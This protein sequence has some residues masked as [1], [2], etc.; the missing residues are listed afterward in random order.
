MKT[1]STSFWL[2]LLLAVCGINVLA[3]PV[4]KPDTNEPSIEYEVSEGKITFFLNHLNAGE[5]ESVD[6]DGKPI[7]LWYSDAVTTDVLANGLTFR[8]N[9]TGTITGA[10]IINVELADGRKLSRTIFGGPIA[11]LDWLNA[12]SCTTAPAIYNAKK[13]DST[14]SDVGTPPYPCCDNNGDGKATGLKDGNCTWLAW[15]RAKKTKG[16]TVPSNWGNASNWCANAAKTT[17]W[18]VSSTPAKDTIACS[19]SIGHV[20]WVTS[21]SSDKKTITIQEQN[22]RVPPSCVSSGGTRSKTYNASSFQYISKSDGTKP[23]SATASPSSG[24][25]TSS[26][27]N[28]TVSSSGA[29]TIY[30]TMVNTYDGSTPS[31]PPAPSPSS[32]NGS[33]AGASAVFQLYASAGQNKKTKLRFVGCNSAGC[34]TAS[35]SYSYQINLQSPSS[36]PDLIVTAVW[37]KEGSTIKKGSVVHPYCTVKNIGT[38]ASGAFRI[39]YYINADQYR[40]DDGVDPLCAGCSATEYVS[41]NNIK[42]GD[43]GNRT[44]RCCA[45]YKGEV[46]ESNESNNCSTISFVVR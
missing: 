46:S 11:S 38:A 21:V 39:A 43:A 33:L 7:D 13:C 9:G 24:S 8:I 32:N 36:H 31:D 37:L 1:N 12:A 17:G 22:C 14:T 5:I 30:Y 23:G 41:N 6:L 18:K 25:W 28:I 16:W 2:A 19:S 15:Y 35:G 10:G 27:Q 29:S 34:G 45:D 26:P 40:D 44:L 20:G 4:V 42:L 3:D